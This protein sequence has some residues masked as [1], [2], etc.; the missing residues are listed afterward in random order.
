MPELS[1]DRSGEIEADGHTIHW[2]YFGKGDREA[3]CLLNGLAM[4][5]TS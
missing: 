2:E 1:P 5:T 4:G 3:I